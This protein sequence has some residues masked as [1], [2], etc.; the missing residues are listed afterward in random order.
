MSSSVY[1]TSGMLPG[2][3]DICILAHLQ[4]RHHHVPANKNRWR[5]APGRSPGEQVGNGSHGCQTI[6]TKVSTHV[7]YLLYGGG[8]S[9]TACFYCPPTTSVNKP[10]QFS[11]IFPVKIGKK[12]T[13][14]YKWGNTGSTYFWHVI[15][16]GPEMEKRMG[17]DCLPEETL[18]D[19]G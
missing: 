7:F 15:K 2:C 8:H 6:G 11:L 1:I 16:C 4:K 9:L 5:P 10:L 18:A 12:E 3:R 13:C 14:L 19:S 17:S